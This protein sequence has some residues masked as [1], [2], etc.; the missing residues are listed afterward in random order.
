MPASATMA[1]IKCLYLCVDSLRSSVLA[2]QCPKSY[3]STDQP[4]HSP[5]QYHTSYHTDVFISHYLNMK[6]FV[7]T[8]LCLTFAVTASPQLGSI[9]WNGKSANTAITIHRLAIKAVSWL[10]SCTEEKTP[11]PMTF[12]DAG[13]CVDRCP[14]M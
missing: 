10:T 1:K 9:L 14:G 5:F 12:R 13:D 8:V 7:L 6:L 2:Y 11:N 4:D 3:I